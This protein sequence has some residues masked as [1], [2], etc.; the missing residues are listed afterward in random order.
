[1]HVGDT[2]GLTPVGFDANGV[3]L[4]ATQGIQLTIADSAVVVDNG[5][6]SPPTVQLMAV[7]PG[8]TTIDVSAGAVSA[9]IPVHVPQ[10]PFEST[11]Y[12]P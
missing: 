1:M 6:V 12:P 9:E 7:G 11:T 3:P 5:L 10:P 2:C 4:Q 8:D